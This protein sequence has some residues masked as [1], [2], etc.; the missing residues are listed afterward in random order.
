MILLTDG[1]PDVDKTFATQL[2]K[3]ILRNQGPEM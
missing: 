2:L 1:W 3:S